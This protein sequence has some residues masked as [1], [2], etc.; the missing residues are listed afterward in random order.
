MMILF[1]IHFYSTYRPD[2]NTEIRGRI[3]SAAIIGVSLHQKLTD[4]LKITLCSEVLFFLINIILLDF[5]I[6]ILYI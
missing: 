2:E 1:L 5:L 4:Y 3:D 6:Y